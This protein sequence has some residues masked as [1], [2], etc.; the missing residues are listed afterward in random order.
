M[1]CYDVAGPGLGV[2]PG[3]QGG[4]RLPGWINV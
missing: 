1:R 2:S 4:F 3:I